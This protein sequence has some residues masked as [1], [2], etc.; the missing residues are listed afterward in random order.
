MAFERIKTA[1]DIVSNPDRYQQDGEVDLSETADAETWRDE[2]KPTITQRLAS[3]KRLFLAFSFLG[4]IVVGLIGAYSS[5]YIPGLY[6]NIWVK[7]GLVAL[8]ATPSIFVLGA[9]WK[10]RQVRQVD[11]LDLMIDGEPQSFYGTYDTDSAGNDVF[12]PYK[13]FDW[14]GTRARPVTLRDLDKEYHRAFAKQGRDPDAEAVIRVED[15]IAGVADTATGTKV[16]VMSAGL[17]LDPYG[18]DSDLYTTPPELADK[19][20]YRELT[21]T[22]EQVHQENADLREKVSTLQ[23][24]KA[25]WREL[26][27]EGREDV[28]DEF[29][30]RFAELAEAGFIT[31]ERSNGDTGRRPS[32]DYDFLDG[33]S[34]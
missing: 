5:R 13:G 17:E 27:E 9:R 21:R 1:Y 8:V 12:K 7:R 19:E 32:M 10:H 4:V 25:W 20:Q 30:D 2:S 29:T 26:A 33:E 24:R 11:E 31:K 3:R 34:E 14:F 22:V 18:R 15:A 23:D 16:M 28:I 6:G